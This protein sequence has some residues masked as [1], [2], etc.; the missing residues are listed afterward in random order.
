M[1]VFAERFL[2]YDERPEEQS[3]WLQLDACLRNNYSCVLLTRLL[4][5]L[6]QHIT[7]LPDGSAF[8]QVVP[9]T[10]LQE[11]LRAYRERKSQIVEAEGTSYFA[12]VFPR[13]S[14]ILIIG[15]AHIT[16]EL[17]QLARLFD[18]ET[19][20]VDPRGVFIHKTQYL[21]PP[22]YL[23]EKYPSEAL[24]D[25]TL[26]PYTYAV[27]L[28]HDPKIDDNALQLLL[29]SE[30]GYIGVLGSKKTHEKRVRRLQD[31]GFSSEDTA[32]IHA[33][34]GLDIHAKT[35]KEIALSIMAEIIQVKNAFL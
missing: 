21:Q 26:D 19:I 22:D 27:I 17:V 6:G 5:G 23:L 31:A 9:D 10:L 14:Q 16:V 33:P 2:A 18:F 30:V 12:Q 4:D 3:A 8:G 11:A 13:R 28:S 34:V 32:R 25:F 7:V 1:Q 20:V 15:S 29:R 35:P 24:P